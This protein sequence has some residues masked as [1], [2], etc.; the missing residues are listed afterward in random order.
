MRKR[1]PFLYEE[2]TIGY[3]DYAEWLRRD[4]TLYRFVK[5]RLVSFAR[6]GY[7]NEPA[8]L[9]ALDRHVRDGENFMSEF[10]NIVTADIYHEKV[11]DRYG[12][13]HQTTDGV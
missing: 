6:R 1:V 12:V 3:P 8:L 9:D 11:I 5:D 4:D 10:M 13:K 2:M 7:A